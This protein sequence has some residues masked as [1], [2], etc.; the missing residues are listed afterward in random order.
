MK[1]HFLTTCA[2]HIENRRTGE[3]CIFLKQ[4]KGL[5]VFVKGSKEPRVLSASEADHAQ[6]RDHDRPA[7]DRCDNKKSEDDFSCDRRVIERKH[8]TAAGRYDFRNEHPRVT[9]ISYNAVSN[10]RHSKRSCHPEPRMV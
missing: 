8:Q 5:S 4:T 6:F 7:E 3:A 2:V 1:C 10:K 9:G